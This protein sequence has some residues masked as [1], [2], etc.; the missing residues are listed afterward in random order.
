EQ[1]YYALGFMVGGQYVLGK[2]TDYDEEVDGRRVNLYC[3]GSD[4]MWLDATTISIGIPSYGKNPKKN[5]VFIGFLRG[6]NAG[7]HEYAHGLRKFNYGM[8]EG[9]VNELGVSLVSLDLLLPI[10]YKDIGK[11]S[12]GM[13]DAIRLAEQIKSGRIDFR[14][15]DIVEGEYL[16]FAVAPWIKAYFEKDGGEVPKEFIMNNAYKTMGVAE[17]LK[18]LY[19]KDTVFRKDEYLAN[20]DKEKYLGNIQPGRVRD[21]LSGVFDNLLKEHWKTPQEFFEKL[22]DALDTGFGCR[23][24]PMEAPDG[25]VYLMPKE[26]ERNAFRG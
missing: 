21:V 7:I 5:S 3:S 20:F 12:A 8:Q 25:F 6:L 16:D 22:F 26:R 23:P 19:R 9:H 11:V 24:S 18:V 15:A 2:Y 1:V 14:Y 10:Y 17:M 13:R 4:A